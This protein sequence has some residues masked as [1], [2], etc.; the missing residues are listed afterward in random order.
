MR[1]PI[2]PRA[3]ALSRDVPYGDVSLD[4]DGHM[5]LGVCMPFDRVAK[6]D[7]QLRAIAFPKAGVNR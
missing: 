4:R 6:R 2:R 1:C 5:S 3:S 7:I